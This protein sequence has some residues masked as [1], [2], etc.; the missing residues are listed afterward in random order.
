[1]ATLEQI[2]DVQI[3]R[4]TRVPTQ[5]GFGTPLIL[6]DSDRFTAGERVRT[7]TSIDQVEADFTSGDKEIELAQDL[8][9]QQVRPTEFKIGQRE[10]GDTAGATGWTE[11]LNAIEAIDG[12][13]YGLL[14]ESVTQADIEEIAQNF[15][16]SRI[17]QFFALTNDAAVPAG[18][19]AN[20]ALNL[21][22]AAL[23]RTSVWYS[24]DT[25]NSVASAISGL[26]LPKAP[27][28][29]NW[30]YKT[31]SGP[32]F[33]D[34]T[35][36]EQQNIENAKANQY[37]RVAGIN[38]TQFGTVASGEYI[39]VIRGADFLQARIQELVYFELINSEK[40]P[41]T[42]NGIAQVENRLREALNLGV[43][44]QII[45]PDF[46]ISTPDVADVSQI[47][48]GNRFLPDVTFEATLTG[49]INKTQI[50]GTLVL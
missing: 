32:S 38:I 50:R 44:N 15:V 4:Q 29:T 16:E 14:V 12:D 36:T 17:K 42:N 9:S 41:Y 19:A 18:T 27:G 10:A 23:D 8:L 5:R 35:P 20:V 6:G 1:M 30:A 25:D 48:K 2:V 37:I 40:I 49:A 28:S 34:L 13:W 11:A 3:T 39:D 43:N 7:Y 33:D 21:N 46:T 45:N 26:Q 31:L 24:G 22:A 47:D